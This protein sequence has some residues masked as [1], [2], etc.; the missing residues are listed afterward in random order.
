M[1]T[2]SYTKK[3]HASTEQ[4]GVHLAQHITA[5]F[6]YTISRNECFP[7]HIIPLN[8][9]SNWPH[10]VLMTSNSTRALYIDIWSSTLGTL[11]PHITNCA[12][13]YF[14]LQISVSLW[15]QKYNRLANTIKIA[16]KQARLNSSLILT[17]SPPAREW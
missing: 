14:S 9:H 16:Y 8:F 6:M 13:I 3:I 5:Q 17:H 12:D 2:V 15:S 1:D 4:Q 7:F 10:A 11:A